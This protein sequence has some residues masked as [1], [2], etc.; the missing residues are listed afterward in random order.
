MGSACDFVA[1]D[2]DEEGGENDDDD[3]NDDEEDAEGVEERR[4]G[5][6]RVWRGEAHF[7]TELCVEGGGVGGATPRTLSWLRLPCDRSTTGVAT[8]IFV[9]ARYL[10][11]FCSARSNPQLSSREI[12]RQSFKIRIR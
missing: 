7:A 12:E 6:E 2:V 11:L 4:L 8:C 1:A 9:V 3:D 10:E 5:V